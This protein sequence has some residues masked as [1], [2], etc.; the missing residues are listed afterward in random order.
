MNN[1]QETLPAPPTEW[2]HVRLGDIV[3]QIS[4]GIAERQSKNNKGIPVTRIETISMCT[5]NLEKVGYLDTLSNELIDKYKLLP[6]DILFSNINSDLHLGKTA[7][8]NYSN[9]ILLHGMNLLL[10]RPNNQLV[11]SSF[12][13]YLF[14]HYRNGGLFLSIAHHAVNQSSINQT[15][16]KDASVYL[17]S[18]F[19]QLRIVAKIEELFTKLDAGVDALKKIKAQL[20]RY[21]QSVLKYAFEGKLTA[22]WREL[23]KDKLEPASAFLEK[24]REKRRKSVKGKYKEL[25]LLDTSDFPDLPKEWCWVRLGE[26]AETIQIGP[27]GSQL[28]KEDYKENGIPIINPKHIKEQNI[29][30]QEMIS[31]DKVEQLS[32]YR[33]FTNDIVLG[34]RGEMGRSAPITFKEDRWLCGTG[35]LFIRLGDSFNSKLYSLILSEKMVVDYLEKSSIGTTMTNLNSMILI[36]LPIQLI[37]AVEQHEI[38]QEIETRFSVADKLEEVIEISL[39]QSERLR[40]SI[41]KIA[42]EGKLVPQDPNDEPAEK[43]LERIKAGR[44]QQSDKVS[45]NKRRSSK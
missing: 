25:S 28:H 21:R 24:I 2:A 29:F 26:I 12:L 37:P 33:L 32:R 35:S 18:L 17:P 4:N 13:N 3:Y 9:C 42:F 16:L 5:I 45:S 38:I 23:H 20:K 27:F 40:Q 6:G 14:N 11:N 36:N 43:L 44:A 1:K 10:I 34:R 15:N 19:E 30:P 41:L 31:E 8:Y 22:E 7:I 39:R